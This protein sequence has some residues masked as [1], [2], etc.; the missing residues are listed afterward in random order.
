MESEG[1]GQENMSVP[2]HFKRYMIQDRKVI[3]QQ[4]MRTLEAPGQSY[5]G[6]ENAKRI[7]LAEEEED[8]RPA[9]IA[10]DLL[11]EEEELLI[12]TLKEYKDVFAWSYRDLKG[13]DPDIC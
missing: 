10:N 12:K 8:P 2:S 1:E 5:D 3:V 9:Y 6:P 11:P 4:P 13:V 7:D